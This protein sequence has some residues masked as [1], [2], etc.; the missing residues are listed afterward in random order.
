MTIYDSGNILTKKNDINLISAIFWN[1]GDIFGISSIWR[2]FDIFKT[3]IDLVNI[4]LN[5]V[6][7][8]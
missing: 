3:I 7:L 4:F 6:S 5:I 1:I 2:Y 8:Q